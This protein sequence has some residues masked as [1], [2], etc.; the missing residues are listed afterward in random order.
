[1]IS[2]KG[3]THNQC[4][5]LLFNSGV[6]EKVNLVITFVNHAM[7]SR[8]TA[9]VV[10]VLGWVSLPCLFVHTSFIVVHYTWDNRISGTPSCMYCWHP[11]SKQV[12]ANIDD[13]LSVENSPLSRFHGSIQL[14]GLH[15]GGQRRLHKAAKNPLSSS[16]AEWTLPASLWL[17][18][19]KLLA[20]W[21]A[22]GSGFKIDLAFIR[23]ARSPPN[24]ID[25]GT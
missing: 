22:R 13:G 5:K 3:S 12:C 2:Q 15:Y 4:L 24:L 7:I 18:V 17:S 8:L 10:I 25:M 14:E 20:G 9:I 23:S 16:C 11:T 19:E 21:R 1:M 6:R